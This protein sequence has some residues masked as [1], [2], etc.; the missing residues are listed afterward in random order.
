MQDSVF[1]CA[2]SVGHCCI[3]SIFESCKAAGYQAM[4]LKGVEIV[5]KWL[6]RDMMLAQ[7]DNALQEIGNSARSPVML[8]MQWVSGL[9]LALLWNQRP[10]R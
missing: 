5:T 7:N 10:I 1:L 9:S 4:L 3:C 2:V 6:E 8:L